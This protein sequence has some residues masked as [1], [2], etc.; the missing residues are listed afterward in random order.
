MQVGES[1]KLIEHCGTTLFRED[2]TSNASYLLAYSGSDFQRIL[3]EFYSST[4]MV[5]SGFIS[6]GVQHTVI[7]HSDSLTLLYC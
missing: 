2:F 1:H 3:S 4:V 7:L 6:N 5:A